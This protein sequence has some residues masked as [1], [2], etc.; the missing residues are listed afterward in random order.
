MMRDS[1]P[2][3]VVCAIWLAACVLGLQAQQSQAPVD[4]SRLGPPV[5]GTVPPFSGSDQFGKTQT[6]E[7]AMGSKGVMLVF[8]RSAD[9]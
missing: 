4:T 5:G 9:W 1:T 7:T 8:F 3:V 6:L 2:T